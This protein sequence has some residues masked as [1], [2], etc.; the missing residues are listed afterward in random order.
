MMRQSARVRKTAIF[1]INQRE[2]WGYQISACNRINIVECDKRRKAAS[3]EVIPATSFLRK[4]P[5]GGC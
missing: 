3:H 1:V 5:S 4:A 2:A